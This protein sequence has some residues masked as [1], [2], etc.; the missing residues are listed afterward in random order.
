[1]RDWDG[2]A[3]APNRFLPAAEEYGV[4]VDVDRWVISR[5]VEA[6]IQSIESFGCKLALD[7]FGTGYGGFVYV[8][9]LPVDYLKI[10]IEFVRDLVVNQASQ[11]VVRAIVGLARG[12]GQQTVAEGAEDDRSLKLLRELGVDYA[13]G[14]GI[15]RPAPVEEVLGG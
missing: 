12:F 1:M 10:D 13:Q 2:A 14:Y 5:A 7:D 4:I 6:F 11:E 9:R 15:A 8:K 3:I